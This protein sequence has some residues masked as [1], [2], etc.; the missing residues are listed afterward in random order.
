MLVLSSFKDSQQLNVQLEIRI[1]L[2]CFVAKLTE[3]LP[4]R[5]ATSI[6]TSCQPSAGSA[7]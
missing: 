2:N 6:Y 5:I 3:G 1:V 7:L 4:E